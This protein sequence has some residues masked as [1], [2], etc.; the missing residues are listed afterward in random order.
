MQAHLS[1]IG[2]ISCAI[3][4]V[5]PMLKCMLVFPSTSCRVSVLSSVFDPS[6]IDFI[7]SEE[8][9]SNFILLYVAIQTSQTQL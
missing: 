3:E 2:I 8:Y 1:V 7:Q 9:K 6:W 5:P 4:K